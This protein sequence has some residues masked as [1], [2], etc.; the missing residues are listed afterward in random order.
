MFK[1]NIL[2]KFPPVFLLIG[3]YIDNSKPGRPWTDF[4][5]IIN[6]IIMINLIQGFMMGLQST[7]IHVEQV[8]EYVFNFSGVSYSDIF[9][10]KRCPKS[11]RSLG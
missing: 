8:I 6:I 5:Y 1:G 11:P 2:N 9:N 10:V 4:M 3:Q 7:N